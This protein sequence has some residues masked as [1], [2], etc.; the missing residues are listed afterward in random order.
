LFVYQL[1]PNLQDLFR[2][3]IRQGA[4]GPYLSMDPESIDL[5]VKAAQKEISKLPPTAQRP[6]I[7]ADREIRRFVKRVL[8]RDFPE[9][10]VLSYE[11]LAPEMNVQLLAKVG[12]TEAAQIE[13]ATPWLAAETAVA[14]LSTA[15]R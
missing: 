15:Q 1:D 11:E 3:C 4:N 9:L 13:H 8:S 5:V 2:N 10:Q 7:V 14:T 12:E 6:A